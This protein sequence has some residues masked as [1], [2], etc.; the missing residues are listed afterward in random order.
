MGKLNILWLLALILV[1]GCKSDDDSNND[2]DTLYTFIN[3]GSGA[4][5]S[6]SDTNDTDELE[7]AQAVPAVQNEAY[8][9]SLPILLFLNVK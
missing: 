6:I 2:D 1:L 3:N 8:P 9:N 7:V 4:V 5:T